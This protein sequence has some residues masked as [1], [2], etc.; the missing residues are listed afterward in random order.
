MLLSKIRKKMHMIIWAFA[1]IFAVSIFYLF[2]PGGLG[3]TGDQSNKKQDLKFVLDIDGKKIPASLFNYMFNMTLEKVKQQYQMSTVSYLQE[4]KIKSMVA[5]QILENELLLKE[6]ARR[7]IKVTSGEVDKYLDSQRDQM[8]GPPEAAKNKGLPEQIRSYFKQS[9]KVKEFRERITGMGLDF[10]DYKTMIHDQLVA[11][12]VA[13]VVAQEL[14]VSES[15][16]VQEKAMG[17][18]KKLKTEDFAAV[19]RQY[20][21]DEAGKQ[22]GGDWGWKT[23]QDID[24]PAL[25]DKAFGMKPNQYSMPIKTKAGF[26]II[27]VLGVKTALTDNA[28]F[29]A[30]KPFIE[31]QLAK[32]KKDKGDKTAVTPHDAERAFEKVHLMNILFKMKSDRELLADWVKKQTDSKKSTITYL[33]PELK[34]FVEFE[35]VA[36]NE[37][38]TQADLDKIKVLYDALVNDQQDNVNLYAQ[39]GTIYELKNQLINADIDKKDKNAKK[40]DPYAQQSKTDEKKSPKSTKFLKEAFESYKKAYDLGNA[41]NSI[42][43]LTAAMGLGRTS[44]A[45]G[46][47]TDKDAKLYRSYARKYYTE[48]VEYA[49]GDMQSMMMIQQALTELDDKAGIARVDKAIKEMQKQLQTDEGGELPPPEPVAPPQAA[50]GQYKVQSAT[51]TASAATGAAPMSPSAPIKGAAQPVRAPA[52]AGTATGTG[53]R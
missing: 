17:V 9:R 29:V 37:A 1:I 31:Q 3:N 44:L 5:E 49:Y 42:P 38:K 20:T 18:L 39:I 16:V 10:N 52:A 30:Q 50:T 46:K 11:E 47:S 36:E 27:K 48:A 22:S 24:D 33:D 51:G 23:R 14:N 13:N 6:A 2:R 28:E 45:I 26:Q 21:E 8:V 41:T 12:K 19:A 32:D 4:M 34:A 43:D 15:K 25:S 7:N 40:D 35:K 53:R